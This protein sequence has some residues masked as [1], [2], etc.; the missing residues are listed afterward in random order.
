ME[1][2]IL[3]KAENVSK[4]FCRDLKQSLWYGVKDIAGELTGG[5]NQIEKLRPGEFWSVDDVSFELKRGECLGLIGPNGAGKSTLLKM[6]NGLIKPDRGRISIRGRVG[7]LIELGAGFNPILTG[8]EN[9]YVNGAV[10]GFTKE[11]INRKLES[12]IDFS[13]LKDFIDSPVQNYSSGMKVRLGFAIASHMEPDVLLI[14]EVLAVGDVGFRSKCFNA[15]N[16]LMEKTAVIFVTHAMPQVSRICSDILVMSHGK[17]AFKGKDIPEGIGHYYTYFESEEKKV[18]GFGKAIVHS[19]NLE[20]NGVNGIDTMDYLDNLTVHLNATID[21]EYRN[22]NISIVIVSQELQNVIQCSS[23]LN[24]VIFNN[25][26]D[27]SSISIDLGIV[28]LNPGIYSIHLTITSEKRKEILVRYHN[29]KF[30]TVVG[31]HVGFAPIQIKGK[32]KFE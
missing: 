18:V 23:H 29:I 3:I 20:V 4:K 19:V 5:S 7:A 16:N 21:K 17:S 31:R 1:Q 32:W 10:L 14:D 22:P 8:M 11:E 28:N 2:E 12:I 9:I 13:E 6:L 26:G 15:I 24:D 25:L 27:L 30:F